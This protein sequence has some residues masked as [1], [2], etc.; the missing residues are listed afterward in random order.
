MSDQLSCQKTTMVLSDFPAASA[1]V[2]P[3]AAPAPTTSDADRS[4]SAAIDRAIT[5]GDFVGADRFLADALR[6][7]PAIPPGRRCSEARQGPRRSRGQLRQAEARRLI[8]EA[9]RFA[10]SKRFH[11]RRAN[12]QDADKQAPGFAET[13]QARAEIASSRTERD[14]RY[15]ERYQYIAAID[16]AFTSEQLWEA[17]RLLADY[18]QRFNQDDEYRM[19]S[20]RLAQMRAAGPYQA[21]VNEARAHIASARQAMERND[22]VEAERQLALADRSAPGFPE[23]GPG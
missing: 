19:R 23:V 10:R 4:L 1:P 8:A 2:A 9:R 21:R 17:E 20:S 22:F 16:Q 5:T 7:Y 18:V 12:A 13:A 15:R 6:R 3:A 14:Q 11:P